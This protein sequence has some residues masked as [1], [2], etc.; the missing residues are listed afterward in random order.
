MPNQTYCE[1]HS[2]FAYGSI[3]WKA[4]YNQRTSVE[5]VFGRPKG[6]RKLNYVRVRGLAKVT[7]HCMMSVLTMQANAL[8]TGRRDLVR[9]VIGYVELRPPLAS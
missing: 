4:V 9:K 2:P 6:H 3:E 7:A 8:A 5:R 1:K